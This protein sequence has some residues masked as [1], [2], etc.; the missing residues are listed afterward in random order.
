ME[1]VHRA[2]TKHGNVEFL[3]RMEKEVGVVSKDDDF[4]DAK[5]MS[6]DIDK[7]PAEY[8]DIIRYLEGMNFPEGATK[9]VR[10]RIAHKSRSY[11]LIGQFL[12][13]CGRD[14][15]LRRAVGKA[16]VPNLLREFHDGFCETCYG[17]ENSCGGIL[18]ADN[19]QGDF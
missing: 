17:G 6:I 12:Y 11:S 1:I 4:L 7:E 16:D 3:S 9:Q 10:T 5:L 14:G 13:F 8:K 18:L 19:V 2:G 15:V